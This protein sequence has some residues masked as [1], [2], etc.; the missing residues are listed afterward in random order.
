LSP[1]HQNQRELGG[2]LPLLR[3]T[4]LDA[5]AHALVE[6]LERTWMPLA[7]ATPFRS[8]SQDGVFIGPF[9]PLLYSPTTS[10]AFIAFQM[11]EAKESSLDKRVREVAILAVGSAWRSPYEVYAHTAAAI[12]AGFSRDDAACL[13]A[14]EPCATL[15]LEE[16]IAQKV[17]LRLSLDHRL[18]DGLYADGIAAFGE[19]GMVDLV[20]LASSYFVICS[21]LNAFEI[22]APGRG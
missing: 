10:A 17:A 21:L 1:N 22:P 15:S 18:D 8:K 19:R 6:T 9:N 13:A 11:V 12:K 5:P 3:P 4:G 2:R 20:I 7:D 16:A 14:G